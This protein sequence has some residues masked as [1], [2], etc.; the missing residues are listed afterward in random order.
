M[1]ERSLT[2]GLVRTGKKRRY[3]EGSELGVVFDHLPLPTR[4]L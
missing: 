2:I 1:E 3:L 4:D